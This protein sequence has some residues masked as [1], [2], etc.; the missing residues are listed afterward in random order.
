[1]NMKVLNAKGIPCLD[2][3]RPPDAFS[4]EA[5]SPIPSILIGSFTR[6]GSGRDIFFVAAILGRDG[7]QNVALRLY[8]GQHLRDRRMKYDAQSIRARLQQRLGRDP[9][10]SKHVV[11]FERRMVIEVDVGKRIQTLEDQINMLTRQL[12]G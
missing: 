2:V 10:A 11:C 6:V 8:I 1:M 12:P 5:R 3:D 7:G 9:P 4:D